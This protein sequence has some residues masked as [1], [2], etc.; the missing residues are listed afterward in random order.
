MEPEP[1]RRKLAALP[2]PLP[3]DMIGPELWVELLL[4]CLKQRLLGVVEV[5]RLECTARRF[6]R[7]V[8]EEA[9][10][11]YVKDYEGQRAQGYGSSMRV[12]PRRLPD[13]QA[14]ELAWRS[15]A[16]RGPSA[17]QR[18]HATA[19]SARV[20]PLTTCSLH[21][22]YSGL[23]S[24]EAFEVGRRPCSSTKSTTRDHLDA[25]LSRG[26]AAAAAADDCAM[27]SH[28]KVRWPGGGAT[29]D[30]ASA[31]GS[32]PTER[33]PRPMIAGSSYFLWI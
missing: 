8:T 6:S 7:A 25:T 14:P 4:I 24:F 10:C 27:F 22:T 11:R 15:P 2:P 21:I 16:S 30:E 18:W 5:T 20:W 13:V 29:A 9:A 33:R 32:A 19:A 23:S 26:A 28:A 17:A 12:T 1:A 31:G 3:V